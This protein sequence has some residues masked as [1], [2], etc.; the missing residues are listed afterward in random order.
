MTE[1]I[2]DR[3]RRRF[4]LNSELRRCI[5][6]EFF[7]TAFFMVGKKGLKK[8]DYDMLKLEVKLN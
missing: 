3:A 2:L 4:R 6:C 5:L 8:Y 7:C 1:N